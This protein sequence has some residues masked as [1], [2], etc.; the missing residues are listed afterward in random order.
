VPVGVTDPRQRDVLDADRMWMARA[1]E[2]ARLGAF[3]DE[4]P[5]GA[6]LV[7]GSGVLLAEAHNRTVADADP[8]AHA[9]V[10]VLRRAAARQGDFRLTDATLYVTLEPC[11][12]CAGALVLARVPRVV[13]AAADP[14]GGMAGTLGNLLDDARLNHRCSVTRGV[15]AEASSDL[16]KAFFRERR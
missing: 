8:T 4:V 9:E 11:A 6:V 12:M 15:L 5:V 2:I 10:T 13:Y 14:K 1:L 3:R 7:L 16:L